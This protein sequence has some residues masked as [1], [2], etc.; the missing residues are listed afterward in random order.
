MN[1]T[2]DEAQDAFHTQR[3]KFTAAEYLFRA[4]TYWTDEMIGD[5]T[6]IAAVREVGHWLLWDGGPR[7]ATIAK[8]EGRADAH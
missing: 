2:F 5:D 4:L 3:S 8:V 1:N 7:D 6:F